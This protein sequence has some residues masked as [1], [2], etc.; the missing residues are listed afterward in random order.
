MS[1][2]AAGQTPDSRA[3][4]PARPGSVAAGKLIP[5]SPDHIVIVIEENHSY[6]DIIGSPNAPFINELAKQGA[7]FSNSYGVRHP[8]EPNYLALFS[9]STQGVKDDSCRH[10]FNKPNLGAELIKSGHSF[11]GYSE[12]L[13]SVG[14]AVCS[15]KGYGRKHNP[16]SDFTNVPKSANMP[17]TKF[18]SDYRKL[19]TVSIVIPN[20]SHDM[21]DGT[22]KEADQ[23][24]KNHMES[25][26][27]WA[28][29]HN[30]LFIL[31]WDEDDFS[32]SNHIPTIFA[33]PMIKAGVDHE[34]INHL[35]VLRTIEDLYHLDH[36]G[37]TG[38][39]SPITGVWNRPKA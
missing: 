6:K 10:S 8:S 4:V 31:T 33:G 11:G 25:Y 12:D 13:P 17:L 32:K 2:I 26:I 28:K 39:S 19:P 37:E 18:P 34:K 35:N 5:D 20:M 38:S 30:S 1:G 36:V 21:H 14:S 3:G 23:W 27:K 9:G 29:Q 24:L 15:M 16:W 22:V 7:V